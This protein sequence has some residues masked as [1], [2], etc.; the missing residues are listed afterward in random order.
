[1]VAVEITQL[2]SKDL[3]KLFNLIS[4]DNFCKVFEQIGISK[5]TITLF[6]NFL[7]NRHQ[8]VKLTNRT[9]VW[10]FCVMECQLRQFSDQ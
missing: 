8:E 6:E 4:Y 3:A 5:T 10:E 1:M 7:I 9:F 2:F